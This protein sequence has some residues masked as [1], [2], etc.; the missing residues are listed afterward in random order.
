MMH[1]LSIALNIVEIADRTARAN[2]GGRV[3][4]V[5]LKLGALSGVAREALAFS[6]ELASAGTALEDSRL[7]IEVIPVVVRCARCRADRRLASIN[8]LR[9]PVC[10][11]P[12]ARIVQGKELRVEAL[13]VV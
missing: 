8:R 7:E 4:T 10:D 13:E 6:W 3:L 11:A 5:Y 12:A 9:C 2:G 1:E